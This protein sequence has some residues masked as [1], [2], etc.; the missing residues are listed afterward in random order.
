VESD[1]GLNCGF[2]LEEGSWKAS[3]RYS[4]LTPAG[5]LL[6]ISK[7]LCRF[8]PKRRNFLTTQS[9]MFLNTSYLYKYLPDG[10]HVILVGDRIATFYDLV[11][12][13]LL[14]LFTW[15]LPFYSF[16]DFLR[17]WNRPLP[18]ML[19]LPSI[20][21]LG[22]K[23]GFIVSCNCLFKNKSFTKALEEQITK[24]QMCLIP[25]VL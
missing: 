18:I 12:F 23:F 11:S 1:F 19:T 10:K 6:V 5:W 2:L 13:S 3:S 17:M 24:T 9:V 14:F 20:W 7:A 25:S 15:V 21:T 8:H 16:K 22:Q 4:E